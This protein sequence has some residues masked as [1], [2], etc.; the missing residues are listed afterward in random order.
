[1][2]QSAKKAMSP[3]T[4]FKIFVAKSFLL[5]LAWSGVALAHAEPGNIR[6]RAAPGGATA[7]APAIAAGPTGTI[8]KPG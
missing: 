8:A 4:T 6:Q 3:L 7:E 5:S 2:L 1:M